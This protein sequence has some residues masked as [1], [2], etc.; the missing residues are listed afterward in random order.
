MLLLCSSLYLGGK[1]RYTDMKCY[2]RLYN[3]ND[4]SDLYGHNQGVQSG[5]LA[6]GNFVSGNCK[7]PPE[8]KHL[9]SAPSF[10]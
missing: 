6:T 1:G 5:Q 10:N 4:I 3:R 8:Q 9:L 2:K 7:S